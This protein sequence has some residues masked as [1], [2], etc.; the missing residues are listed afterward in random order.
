MAQHDAGIDDNEMF[1]ESF[2]GEISHKESERDG[3]VG[4][5]TSREFSAMPSL[6]LV[7]KNGHVYLLP[8]SSLFL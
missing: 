8:L 1:S 6:A 7:P 5:I 2:F 3:T 4:M